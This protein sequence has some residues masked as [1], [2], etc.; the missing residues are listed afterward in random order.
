MI[1]YRQRTLTDEKLISATKTIEK[2]LNR[3]F[4]EFLKGTSL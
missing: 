2:E 1:T 3:T 4:P